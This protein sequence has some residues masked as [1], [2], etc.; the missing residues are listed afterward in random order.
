MVDRHYSL[1]LKPWSARTLYVYAHT[2]PAQKY[3][4]GLQEIFVSRLCSQDENYFFLPWYGVSIDMSYV[5]YWTQ[6]PAVHDFISL[7][8]CYLKFTT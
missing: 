3:S 2:D 1:N 6:L 5:S 7:L 4:V 8:Q